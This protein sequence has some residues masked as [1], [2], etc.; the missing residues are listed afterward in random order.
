VTLVDTQ[1][2]TQEQIPQGDDLVL[3]PLPMP[4]LTSPN[5]QDATMADEANSQTLFD[6]MFNRPA[7]ITQEQTLIETQEGAR[8]VDG[9]TLDPIGGDSAMGTPHPNP[10]ED[11]AELEIGDETPPAS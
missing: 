4:D 11:D 9:L 10:E 6:G 3:P 2:A 1:E 7:D 8:I 5:P